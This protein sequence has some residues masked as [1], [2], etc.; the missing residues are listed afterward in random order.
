MENLENQQSQTTET[1]SLDAK[2][3]SRFEEIGSFQAYEY[4][5][6]DSNIRNAQKESFLNGE[7]ENP[8]LDY[9]LLDVDRIDIIESSLMDLKQDILDHEP[10]EIVRDV[11]RWK[12][13][14]KVAEL[15]MMKSSHN[16]DMRRFERYSK[17]IYGKPSDEVFQY[18]IYNLNNKILKYLDS[19]NPD[20]QAAAT[21]LM[22]VMG[23]LDIRVANPDIS[24]PSSDTVEL[25]RT[26]TKKEFNH[27]L[28]IPLAEGKHD[29]TS[30]R[31]AFEIALNQ[32]NAEGWE[33][34][35]SDNVP[36]IS[37]NQEQRNITIPESRTLPSKTRLQALLLHEA[38]THVARR[39]NGENTKLKLL[40]LGLDRYEQG[41]EGVA[42]MREQV[43][44]DSVNDFSGLEGHLA[45]SL[46]MG[47]DGKR[48]D[49][50]E[51]YEI[52]EKY[53]YFK[54]ILAKKSPEEASISAK[55][56]AYK[57]CIRTFRGT[58]CKTRG[59]CFTKDMIYREGSI[60]VWDVIRNNPDEMMRFSV[61]KYDPSNERHIYVLE[62]LGISDEDLITLDSSDSETTKTST[63]DQTSESHT[64][65]PTT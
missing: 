5:N 14:E 2:W 52:L 21:T 7:I 65:S 43:L 48:K 23:E 1:E 44:K 60:G 39:V 34:V 25:A 63:P 61:G 64:P 9:P 27:I 20:I 30:I 53:F 8:D 29:S 13:N 37:T 26:Q 33:A 32:L 4:F 54:A 31:N 45:I 41:E 50:R 3:Y 42:T 47:L 46:A 40:S 62:Q 22:Q 17:Y 19:D 59:V 16:G 57:R 10:D 58:D 55:N 38:G 28:N 24:T 49:F 6:G 35:V 18:T 36:S 11:Y 15:R 51:T 56:D 12:I